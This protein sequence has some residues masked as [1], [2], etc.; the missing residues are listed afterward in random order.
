MPERAPHPQALISKVGFLEV[1]DF[2]KTAGELR[3]DEGTSNTFIRGDVDG[4]G[5]ADFAIHLDAVLS[6]TKDDFIL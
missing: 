3:I 2:S 5:T 1:S 4:D 6:L